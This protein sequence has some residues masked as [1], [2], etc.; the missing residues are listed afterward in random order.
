MSK[1]EKKKVYL[2]I[3]TSANFLLLHIMQRIDLLKFKYVHFSH[4]HLLDASF[5]SMTTNREFL[6]E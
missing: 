6:N 4:S 2:K 1:V 5:F 3:S